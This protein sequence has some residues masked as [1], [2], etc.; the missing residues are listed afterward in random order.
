MLGIAP[1]KTSRVK[2]KKYACENRYGS[3]FT[4]SY[5]EQLKKPQLNFWKLFKALTEVLQASVIHHLPI[6][7]SKTPKV[8]AALR[9]VL[10]AAWMLHIATVLEVQHVSLT[11]FDLSVHNQ[12]DD[13]YPWS[14]L[15]ATCDYTEDKT[16]LCSSF[17]V[18]IVVCC[19]SPTYET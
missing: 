18:H 5:T 11:L 15:K 3:G 14:D 13:S 4:D 6:V 9:W 7:A 1:C 12:W 17:I 16:A 2:K 10:C 8:A 19:R